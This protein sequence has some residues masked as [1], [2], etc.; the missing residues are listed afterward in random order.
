MYFRCFTPGEDALVTELWRRIDFRKTSTSE[1]NT[2]IS[3]EVFPNPA[4]AYITVSAE[5]IDLTGS[6]I[7][8]IDVTGRVVYTLKNKNNT[9]NNTSVVSVNIPVNVNDGIYFLKLNDSKGKSNSV[10]LNVQK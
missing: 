7:S 5:G 10:L 4:S 9:S 2:E 1:T 8:L 6:T 3:V